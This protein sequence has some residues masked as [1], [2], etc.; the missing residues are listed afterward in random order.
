MEKKIQFSIIYY[1]LVL[2]LL[3]GLQYWFVSKE[4]PEIPYKDFKEYVK[5]GAVKEVAIGET[6]IVGQL[7]PLTASTSHVADT[8]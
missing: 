4:I 8:S 2:L 5:L 1:I 3:F 6:K 7:K